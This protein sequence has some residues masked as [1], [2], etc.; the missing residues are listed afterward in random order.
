MEFLDNQKVDVRITRSRSRPIGL[1]T[2]PQFDLNGKYSG[3]AMM[4]NRNGLML[5]CHFDVVFQHSGYLLHGD[6]ENTC[7]DNGQVM[8][9]INGDHLEATI[10]SAVFE[11][12]CKLSAQLFAG[13]KVIAGSYQCPDGEN[14]G[15]RME[16]KE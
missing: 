13:G 9:S 2:G 10:A 8:G 12:H 5:E 4:R 3:T 14:S 11:T 1:P 15:F 16:R 6:Y 7:S